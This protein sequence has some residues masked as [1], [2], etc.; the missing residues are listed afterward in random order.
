MSNKQKYIEQLEQFKLLLEEWEYGTSNSETRSLINKKLKS[1]RNIVL[2]AGVLKLYTISPPPAIGGFVLKNIDPFTLIFN[3][4]YGESMI[5]VIIDMLDEAVGVIESNDDFNLNK[6]PVDKK[7][8][9]KKEKTSNRVFLVHGHDKELKETTARFLEK[10]GLDP[11]ILHEQ[12]NKGLTIIEKFEEYSDVSFAVVL[13]TPDDFGGSLTSIENKNKRA[14]Q[15]VIFELGYFL[16]KL[17]RKNVVGLIKDNIEIPSDYS[18]IMYIAVDNFDA[19]KMS[20]AKEIK[21]AGL[22]IDMNV[23]F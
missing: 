20:L 14:R 3:P 2:H 8:N 9:S 17:G 22:K 15:N 13:L 12:S 1:V 21:T 23:A 18:G 16:G 6:Q 5:P 4:P 19:W 11:I 10:L 7:T